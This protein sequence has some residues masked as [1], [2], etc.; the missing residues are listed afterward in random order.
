MILEMQE[1][2]YILREVGVHQALYSEIHF[3]AQEGDWPATFW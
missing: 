3:S 1:F 2:G